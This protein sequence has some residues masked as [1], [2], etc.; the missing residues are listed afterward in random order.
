ML[1]TQPRVFLSFF[2]VLLLAA[3]SAGS[4]AQTQTADSPETRLQALNV[5][6]VFNTAEAR[7]GQKHFA[8]VEEIV[9]SGTLPEVAKLY[10]NANWSGVDLQSQEPI[11]GWQLQIVVGPEGQSYKLS[12]IEKS[13]PCRFGYFSDEVGIIYHGKAINCPVD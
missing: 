6:R 13:G 10:P 3:L 9:R 12:L 5:V 2:V 4:A 1:A 8:S 7:F 11:P